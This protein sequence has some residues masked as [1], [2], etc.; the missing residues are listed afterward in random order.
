MADWSTDELRATIVAYLAMLGHQERGEAYSKSGFRR[1]LIKGRLKGRSEASIE[2]RMRN[3]SAV[4]DQHGRSIL[5][6][7]L[8]AANVGEKV[9][10]VIWSIIREMD[11]AP[12]R[13]SRSNSK[14]KKDGIDGARRA[15]PRIIYFN[16]G[17][18]KRYEGPDPD[19]L[20][21][22]AHGYL[23]D[24]EHG[25]ECHNFV[26]KEAMVRGYR[27]PGN[28]EQTNLTRLGAKRSQESLKGVLVVWMA[29]E[30]GTGRTLVVGWYRDA[31]V[32]RTARDGD[33]D[34]NGERIHFTAEAQ[35][36]DAVLLPAAARTFEIRSSRVAP[37]EGFGQKPTWFGSPTVDKRVWAYVQTWL[38]GKRRTKPAPS[39]KPP[40]NLNP[41]LRRE[42]ERA[43]VE[44][45]K[46]YYKSLYGTQCPVETVES[47]A[48]GW[49]LEVF[50]RTQ[51]LLVEVKGLLNAKLCC[52]LT[53]N[54]YEKM[55]QPNNSS[56]YVV[57]VVNNA[58]AKAPAS[59]VAS[60][61]EHD[62]G[63]VWIT[64]DGRTLL[65]DERV[66]AVLTAS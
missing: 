20:T 42:V 9:S 61:F 56:R 35:A 22:G 23:E 17:W 33:I 62:E 37:G 11:A 34:F 12:P 2:F 51:P 1:A 63:R 53:P 60:V 7:Y 36:Q 26:A 24:H 48:K 52:E 8:P 59:P 28:Q 54:E 15:Q 39:K 3:I 58:L 40:R 13:G 27:P 18:M 55:M 14:G 47:Q 25:A 57:F 19:D 5:R 4:L 38:G 10:D 64:A 16:V 32:Y 21:I 66:G 44:H 41:E 46:A 6:G 49:D 31:T 45:A 43:A 29:R 30:P 65:F 50:N